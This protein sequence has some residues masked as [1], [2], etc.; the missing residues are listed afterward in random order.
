MKNKINN[1]GFTLI[2]LLV[3][4]LIIGILAAIA[5]PQY[6]IAVGKAKFS[7]LKNLTRTVWDSAQRYYLVNNTY[8]QTTT[9]LDIGLNIKEEKYSSTSKIL[10]FTTAEGISCNIWN[11]NP[12]LFAACDREIAGKKIALYV[13]ADGSPQSCVV[14]S[15]VDNPND[16]AN[17]ICQ[18]ETNR[19]PGVHK[20]SAYYTY[21][22]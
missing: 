18:N 16:I 19:K 21:N 3:V 10:K 7:T 6:R 11:G 8:P 20:D 4:V 12:N 13:K 17:K 15:E 2:E 1:K 14:F 22:Y 9:D 5:L